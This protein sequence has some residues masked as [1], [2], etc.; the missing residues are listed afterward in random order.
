MPAL[1]AA[2]SS[3]GSSDPPAE[4]GISSAEAVASGAA[5]APEAP[6]GPK[7]PSLSGA[8]IA[9]SAE[10][11]ALYVADE[12]HSA[13][14]TVPLPFQRDAA[15]T[16]LPLPGRPAQV[17][18]TSGRVFVTVRE[19][20]DTGTG[21][22]LVFAREQGGLA[23][24]ARIVLPPDAWG[25][26]ITPDERRAIVTSAWTGKLSVIDL[27]KATVTATLQVAREPRGIATMPSGDRAYV[28]HLVGSGVTRID[29][30]AGDAP[31]A[32]AVPLPA[33]P[34]RSPAGV[35]LSASLGYAAVVNGGGD[36]VYFPRHA[37]GALG[38]DAWWGTPAVDVLVPGHEGSPDRALSARFKPT[39]PR[40]R[41][42]LFEQIE[43]GRSWSPGVMPHS[44]LGVDAFV[45]PRAA[46]FRPSEETLLVASEG[47]DELVELDANLADPTFGV[48]RRYSIALYRE[49]YFGVASRCGAPS[50]IALSS[51]ESTAYVHCRST[52]DIVM[53]SLAR[54]DGQYHSVPPPALKLSSN[55]ADESF[56]LG[57]RLY[58]NASENIVSGKLACAGC[59]PEGRDDGHVWHEVRFTPDDESDS[60]LTGKEPFVNFVGHEAQADALMQRWKVKS[61]EVR[62]APGMVSAAGRPRQTP[63]LVARVAAHGPYGWQGESKDL[64]ARLVAG[65]KLHRWN[66][67]WSSED[68]ALAHAGPLVKFLREGLVAPPR[69]KSALTAEAQRGKEIFESKEAMCSSCHV[70]ATGYTD[71]SVVPLL[72]A[73]PPPRGFAPDTNEAFKTPSLLFVGGSPPYFHDGRYATLD[74]LVEKNADRMGRTSQLSAEDKKALVAYLETL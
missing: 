28:S 38:G 4:S 44:E 26:A 6:R 21:A 18:T 12:D 36:R 74:E 55:E 29:G 59:H 14:R 1:V 45:Q 73:A 48:I 64:P 7:A 47:M 65:F 3:P 17:L 41:N 69:T 52:D 51:D 72:P 66:K 67:E 71:R 11:D 58:Y 33:A 16:T 27:E 13:L 25:L 54:G 2:C 9:R 42:S 34:L 49:R 46:V 70:A 60:F 43:K 8:S 20:D 61:E 57:R 10:G 22:L 53:V 40:T 50:G 68:R 39:M 37:I 63:M 23:E 56:S 35:E 5:A 31:Q 30:L 24:K 32:T 15:V 62:G 19:L